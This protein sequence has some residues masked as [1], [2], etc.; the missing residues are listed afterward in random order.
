[1]KSEFDK[2]HCDENTAMKALYQITQARTPIV[3]GDHQW[4][5]TNLPVSSSRPIDE[6]SNERWKAL[7][8]FTLAPVIGNE[9]TV[10]SSQAKRSFTTLP[11][12]SVK[13]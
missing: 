8:G 6:F 13:R 7:H 3:A 12:T 1:M 10:Q 4:V 9:S 11:C 5:L 2:A